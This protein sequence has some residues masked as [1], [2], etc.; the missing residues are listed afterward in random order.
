MSLL[1]DVN[2]EKVNLN[3]MKYVIKNASIRVIS[4]YYDL[5]TGINL[6]VGIFSCKSA[7]RPILN[8]YY[9]IGLSDDHY[10][11]YFSEESLRKTT[12]LD[13]CYKFLKSL[14]EFSKAKVVNRN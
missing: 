6:N 7:N 1:M 5:K 3:G 2:T 10:V 11:D 13:A 12:F 14:P 4:V 8:L 9:N